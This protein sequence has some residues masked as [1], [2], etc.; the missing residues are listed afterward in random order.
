ML[1]SVSLAPQQRAAKDLQDLPTELKNS[2]LGVPLFHVPTGYGSTGGSG[3]NSAQISSPLLSGEVLQAQNLFSRGPSPS[4]LMSRVFRSAKPRY[5]TGLTGQ[6]PVFDYNGRLT[7]RQVGVHTFRFRSLSLFYFLR[8]QPWTVLITYS[9]VLYLIIVL[10]ITAAYYAWGVECGAAMN[11]VSAI[12][13]TVVS[14]AANGGYM[15]EDG[16]TMTDATHMCYRGR[17]AIVMVCSYVNILFVGLVAALVVSKAEYT[18]KLG[19]RV[20]FSDF[21]TLATVPGR[22]DQWRLVF[23]VANVDNHIPLARGK[24]RLFCVTAEPLKECHIHQQQLQALRHSRSVKKLAGSTWSG[25]HQLLPGV[26]FDGGGG[27]RQPQRTAPPPAEA[28]ENL[29]TAKAKKRHAKV[30]SRLRSAPAPPAPHDSAESGSR[31]DRSGLTRAQRHHQRRKQRDRQLHKSGS[32]G[33]TD[34][35]DS[36]RRHRGQRSEGS[37]NPQKSHGMPS[38]ESRGHRSASSGPSRSSSTASSGSDDSTLSTSAASSRFLSASSS[39]KAT[40][41][42]RTRRKAVSRAKAPS[43]KSQ[44]SSAADNADVDKA[45][46]SVS[47]QEGSCLYAASPFTEV[48]NEPSVAFAGKRSPFPTGIPEPAVSVPI[49]SRSPN[50]DA[51]KTMERVHLC[52]HEM[53]WTC[54][55]ETYLDRGERGQLSLWYPA[56]IIHIIDERSPLRPFLELPH[57][58]ASLG[59]GGA[60]ADA[61]YGFP[62]RADLVR[63]HFQIV[64][65]F[66]ATEM[67]T[68]SAITTKRTYTNEDIVAHYKFSDRLVHVHPESSEVLLDFHYFNALLPVN[69]VEPSTTESDM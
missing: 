20:V 12:Y 37:L 23:R 18:G 30:H 13:F 21:C 55:G 64:A 40:S 9:V 14:L 22:V 25:T 66:D 15:G 48:G 28:D 35:A 5:S 39:A 16:D 68:G 34:E 53:R 4:S 65:V 29:H 11:A 59:S 24:L 27:G 52:V 41:S 60:S 43:P 10:L 42:T 36:P 26:E 67:E 31:E 69:L 46:S 57:V 1:R 45:N 51:G 47:S 44:S 2:L 58:A 33:H 54:A 38:T 8:S 6:V 63:Q 19:H 50:E 7:T 3:A 17:T 61:L 49:L 32:G 62:S 56:D